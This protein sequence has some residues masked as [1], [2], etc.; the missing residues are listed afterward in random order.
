MDEPIY[1]VTTE[2]I[3]SRLPEMYR[4][5]DTQNEYQ[6]KTYLS[7]ITDELHD[8]D[9]LDARFDYIPPEHNRYF[10]EALTPLTTYERPAELED[11]TL[12]W[13]PLSQTS[14]LLDARTADREWLVWLA[15]LV[16]TDI[17]ILHDDATR[18]DAIINNYLG[19][20]VGATES[21]EN[22]VKQLLTGEKFSRVYPHKDDTLLL[23]NMW[24]ILIVTKADETPDDLDVVAEIERKGVKP[25]GVVLWHIAYAVTWTVIELTLPDWDT[26]ESIGTWDN[27][28]LGDPEL[29]PT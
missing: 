22:A 23:T 1:S 3:Y 15:Q 21:V 11:P 28:E 16:G 19:Y 18:R 27:L 20:L 12:G 10:Q 29:L 25:V 17:R 6:L 24:D 2:R 4:T 5:L 9:L 13:A 8:I 26:I 14:D 7:A